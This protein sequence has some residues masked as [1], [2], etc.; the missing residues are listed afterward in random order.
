MPEVA[1]GQEGCW[2]QMCKVERP[3]W[4]DLCQGWCERKVGG[5]GGTSQ[6]AF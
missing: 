5:W 2:P 1:P 4:N 3:E 6:E